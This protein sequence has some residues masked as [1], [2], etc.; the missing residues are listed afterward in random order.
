[1]LY[2]YFEPFRSNW[3]SKLPKPN[4]MS[5]L[6]ITATKT[7]SPDKKTN[8]SSQVIYVESDKITILPADGTAKSILQ[9]NG[10]NFFLD[11]EV[12]E[13]G[14]ALGAEDVSAYT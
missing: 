3:F 9:A 13:L 8:T 7:I 5:K 10:Y 2:I 4:K 11:A 1:L 6:L 12:A 14:T